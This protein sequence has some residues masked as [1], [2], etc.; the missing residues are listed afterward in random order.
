MFAR[1]IVTVALAVIM[2]FGG[3]LSIAPVEQ[4]EAATPWVGIVAPTRATDWSGAGVQGGIPSANWTQCGAT[5][6]AYNGSPTT[7]QNA[8]NNCGTNQYGCRPG[9]CTGWTMDGA[10]FSDRKCYIRQS[11]EWELRSP[12]RIT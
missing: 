7:I 2:V 12:A 6:N 10:E 9:Q 5:V 11:W 3:L 4:A 1:M 8:I